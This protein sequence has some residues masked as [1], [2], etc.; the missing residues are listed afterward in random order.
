MPSR[1]GGATRSAAGS[2]AHAQDKTSTSDGPVRFTASSLVFRQEGGTLVAGGW[3]PLLAYDVLS[4][5]L[6]PELE[7]IPAPARRQAASDPAPVPAPNRG[8]LERAALLSQ[9]SV[10]IAMGIY[11]CRIPA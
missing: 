2:A 1:R 9:R 8:K 6:D 7:H 10:R 5:N 4:A 11:H 3:Q